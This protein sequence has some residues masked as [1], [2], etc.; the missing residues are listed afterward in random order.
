[1]WFVS[2][3]TA[4]PMKCELFFHDSAKNPYQKQDSGALQKGGVGAICLLAVRQCQI[5]PHQAELAVL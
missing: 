3:Y 5:V 1:M 4:A 2:H